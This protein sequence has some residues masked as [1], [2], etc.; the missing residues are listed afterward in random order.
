MFK[1]YCDRRISAVI[2]IILLR[3]GRLNFRG[4]SPFE[5]RPYVIVHIVDERVLIVVRTFS[6]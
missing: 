3:E 6:N 1:I 4:R 5:N 2:I